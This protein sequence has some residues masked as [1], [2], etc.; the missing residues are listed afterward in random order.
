MASCSL[1][2]AGCIQRDPRHPSPT[3]SHRHPQQK[4]ASFQAEVPTFEEKGHE[5]DDGGAQ[6]G[7]GQAIDPVVPRRVLGTERDLSAGQAG[8]T[9][10]AAACHGCRGKKWGG[11]LLPRHPC[12]FAAFGKQRQTLPGR[13][14]RGGKGL[15]S[16][17][18]APAPNAASGSCGA[19]S[20]QKEGHRCQHPGFP[21]PRDPLQFSQNLL[22]STRLIP[23]PWALQH[24]P[25]RVPVSNMFGARCHSSMGYFGPCP[26]LIRPR[27]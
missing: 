2:R 12:D 26:G 24:R 1:G 11:P 5:G 18:S 3:H 19:T 4:P 8:D 15:R 27:G 9:A 10:L 23:P 13:G 25:L 17:A 20:A 16:P 7:D 14:I 21:T 6:L 22:L